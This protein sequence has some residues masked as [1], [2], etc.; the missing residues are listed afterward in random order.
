MRHFTRIGLACFAWMAWAQN[1]GIGTTTPTERL[2][3]AGGRL[4]VRAYSGT[5][6]RLAT[7]DPTGV[8]G[9]LA[10]T[11]PGDVL[12]W[13]GTA[14]VP[15]TLSVSGDNWGSQVAQ[16]N[17]PI[18]GD[19]TAANPIRLQPGTTAGQVL[20]WN[21]TNWVAG[22]APG[23]NWGS[24]A[25]VTA[26]PITGDG[27][28]GNP[29]TF[30]NGTAAGQVW[31]WNGTAWML[32]TLSGDNWGT[33]VAQT[34]APITGD[35]TVAN[36]IRLQPGTTAGQVLQWNGTAWVPA[37]LS[38]S[39]D[40][41]GSQTAI[42]A[43]PITGNGTTGSPITLTAGTSPGQIL[44]WTGTAWTV[45]TPA[46]RNGLSFV[47]TPTPAIELGGTL[48]KNTDIGLAGFN[49]TLSGNGKVGIGL[50]TPGT[51]KVHI[52]NTDISGGPGVL[53]E[54]QNTGATHGLS[55]FHISNTANT[56]AIRG[57]HQH[58]SN[59]VYG[60]AGTVTSSST[61]AAG[62]L[63]LNSGAGFGVAGQNTGSGHGVYGLATQTTG[64][65]VVATHQNT[66]GA[67]LVAIGGAITTPTAILGLGTSGEAIDAVGRWI[68][69]WSDA[70]QGGTTSGTPKAGL[71]GTAGLFATGTPN[72]QIGVIG[73]Y[74]YEGI[75]I[76]GQ[77]WTLLGLG[78]IAS[79][80]ATYTDIGVF[81]SAGDAAL[82]G[83]V[84]GYFDW[85][86][87]IAG[88]MTAAS[89]S[90][91]I[92]HPQKPA[93]H[94]LRHFCAE[95]PEPNTLYRGTVQLS[96]N[97]EAIVELPSYFEALNADYTYHLTCIGD[98]APVYVKEKIQNGRFVIAGGKPGMEVSWLVIAR[99]NDPYWDARP[100]E[101]LVEIPKEP[102]N[103]GKYLHPELY[104][105]DPSQRA[106][107]R[108]GHTLEEIRARKQ[109]LMQQAQ[110]KP[111]REL[112]TYAPRRFNR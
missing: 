34:N 91:L 21:G 30:T 57:E 79:P 107:Y 19:G 106:A 25:A 35:G 2:D 86:V 41:W 18:L 42:T 22:T 15:A 9:T 81:G 67:G 28:P 11:A 58:T 3:V 68:G 13:N 93:T 83:G 88:T 5:G 36:P 101:H 12:Q 77:A 40:N 27:T 56:A 78:N 90:F 76:Q 71:I 100:E 97:G 109:A 33:Q 37:T 26:G 110:Q 99:R 55:V 84:A 62:V 61:S 85:N 105:A 112:K 72:E 20:Q 43:G 32:T 47:T 104:G 98:Y 14:W 64:A 8:F 103:I 50:A 108:R 94:Y 73:Q 45:A 48:I 7:V 75:G 53:I 92:D 95:G 38:V 24:Q 51:A 1:F 10:G 6:T 17:A 4:R 60:V 52:R 65:G 49:L 63:G 102:D 23:D 31:Q 16:T 82:F 66:N 96:P 44:I 46:V 111:T 54:Q 89:K 70:S 87:D 29:I 39:G 69:S 80:P 59:A 74:S